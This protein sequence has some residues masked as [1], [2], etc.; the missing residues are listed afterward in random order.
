MKKLFTFRAGFAALALAMLVASPALSQVPAS[1]PPYNTDIGV[2]LSSANR[3]A[4]TYNSANQTNLDKQG[5]TCTLSQTAS[6]GSPSTTYG[7]Q[8]YDAATATWITVL[9]SSAVT[10]YPTDTPNAPRQVAVRP[11]IQT[12]SDPTNT[13]SVSWP[14]TR[15]WRVFA[16]V[17]SGTGAAGPA[18]TFSVGCNYSK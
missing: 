16:T 15:V 2:V 12:T 1:N 9:T 5:V 10:G 11:G 14:L 17:G 3:T 13:Y 18:S 4:A 8:E 6:S 7:I